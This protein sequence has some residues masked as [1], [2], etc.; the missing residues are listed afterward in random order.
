MR[1]KERPQR[2]CAVSSMAKGRMLFTGVK[3]VMVAS[4]LNMFRITT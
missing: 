4:A 1:R 2:K 3:N